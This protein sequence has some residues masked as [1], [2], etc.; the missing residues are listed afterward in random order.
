MPAAP[1]LSLPPT[2]VDITRL[3]PVESSSL[4]VASR[5]PPNAWLAIA[6]GKLASSVAPATNAWFALSSA[7]P[8]AWSLPVPPMYVA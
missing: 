1:S 7:M 2:N 4:T 5:M 8:A 6:I 3:P